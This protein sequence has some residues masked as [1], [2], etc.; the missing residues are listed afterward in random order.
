MQGYTG[1]GQIIG[2]EAHDIF[3]FAS[4]LNESAARIVPDDKTGLVHG[5]TGHFAVQG[6]VVL[7]RRAAITQHATMECKTTISLHDRTGWPR[8]GKPASHGQINTVEF[9]TPDHLPHE[10][11]YD[12]PAVAVL[13][14]QGLNAC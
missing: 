11:Q 13:H 2:A 8:H 14:L 5:S 10:G 6:M 1:A 3:N 12:D 4:H 9:D 7:R